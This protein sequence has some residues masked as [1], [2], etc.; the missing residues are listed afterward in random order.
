MSDS[1]HRRCKAFTLIELLVVVSI[2]ALL[3]SILLPSLK[4]AREQAKRTVCM[5]HLRG[6]SNAWEIYAIDHRY[7]PPLTHFFN[8]TTPTPQSIDVNYRRQGTSWRRIEVHGFGPETFDALNVHGQQWLQIY[9]RNKIFHWSMPERVGDWRNFGLLW[10]SGALSDPRV[11]FCPSERDPDQSWNTPLNPWP[12]R[13]ET[14]GQPGNSNIAN[15]T[16]SSYERRAALTGVLWDRIG[17][18]ITIASDALWPDS[19][20]TRHRT[21]VSVSYRDGHASFV[22]SDRFADWWTGSDSWH[23]A[24]SRLK[25]LEMSHWLDRQAGR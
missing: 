1:L 3:I 13:V 20:K 5:A 14:A 17:S 24:E 19:V 8:A 9:H 21:G 11:F 12:P 22:A 18:G 23:R 6:L 25:F 7:S 2:V 15:H 16:E 10:S 4:R